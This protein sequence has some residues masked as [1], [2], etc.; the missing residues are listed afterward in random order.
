MM[1]D[2][3]ISGVGMQSE[4]DRPVDWMV[5]FA[6]EIPAAGTFPDPLTGLA[7][8]H[9]FTGR[10]REILSD[11]DPDRRSVTVFA[12]NLDSFRTLNTLRG[13]RVGDEVLKIIAERLVS[14]T[15]S[16]DPGEAGS[17]ARPRDTLA[18]L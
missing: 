10:L 8:R 5:R 18:R 11:P 15:R 7:D 14:N 4:I 6:G 3:G 17:A 1:R 13:F 9:Q 12:L 16:R 2:K